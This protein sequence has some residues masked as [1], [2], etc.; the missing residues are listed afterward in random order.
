MIKEIKFIKELNNS[1]NK[2]SYYRLDF[3]KKNLLYK[4]KWKYNIKKN[5]PD[6]KYR[7]LVLKEISYS[8]P[9]KLCKSRDLE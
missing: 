4:S 1:Y 9:T 3:I 5:L 2:Y 6:Y 7:Y 8:N